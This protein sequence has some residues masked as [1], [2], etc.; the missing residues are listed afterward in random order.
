MFF[1]FQRYGII[2]ADNAE[3]IYFIGVKETRKRIAPKH[4]EISL[5]NFEIQNVKGK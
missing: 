1:S 5:N 4:R 3:E 2:I